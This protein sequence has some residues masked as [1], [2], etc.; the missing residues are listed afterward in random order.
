MAR[1]RRRHDEI[2]PRD[3]LVLDC[4]RNRR[5][6]MTAYQLIEALRGEGLSA[7][8][9]VYRVLARLNQKGLVHRLQSLN[10]FIA[11][12]QAGHIG[13]PVFTICDSC[14]AVAEIDAPSLATRLETAAGEARFA[15]SQATIEVRGH[16]RLCAT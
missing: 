13:V 16:C 14:G 5:E 12:T 9:S 15:I 2:T 3:R 8:P 10:A 4:L 1:G 7:P 6:P 11:C